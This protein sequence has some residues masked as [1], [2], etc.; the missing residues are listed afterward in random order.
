LGQPTALP[1][2][3]LPHVVAVREA[4]PLVA[5]QA[6]LA[7]PGAQRL[8]PLSRA[9]NSYEAEA[10]SPVP[11]EDDESPPSRSDPDAVSVMGAMSEAVSLAGAAGGE[12]GGDAGG[13][14]YGD[15]SGDASCD[16]S[17]EAFAR[18]GDASQA[19]G[20]SHSDDLDARDSQALGASHSDDLDVRGDP[21]ARLA[22]RRPSWRPRSFD[23]GLGLAASGSSPDPDEN[24]GWMEEELDLNLMD[25]FNNQRMCSQKRMSGMADN[26][27]GVTDVAFFNE[28]KVAQLPFVPAALHSEVA[29]GGCPQAL[30]DAQWHATL[31]PRA[32]PAGAPAALDVNYLP[33]ERGAYAS[34]ASIIEME[35]D[36]VEA[37]HAA[38]PRREWAVQTGA[39]GLEE[40]SLGA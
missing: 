35:S 31:R 10:S 25:V 32:D 22:A 13:D 3:S 7:A 5:T 28:L 14:A 39:E 23:S 11:V 1:R 20:A 6:R 26:V 37:L 34:V 18:G 40:D 16:A 30:Q 38:C 33:G 29:V 15:A 17:G 27:I 8:P 21:A 19:L 36:D 12:A 24:V 9:F 4:D 2:A